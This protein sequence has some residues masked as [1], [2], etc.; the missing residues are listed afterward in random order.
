MASSF[1]QAA[2]E[3]DQ[4]QRHWNQ[5]WAAGPHK[6]KTTQRSKEQGRQAHNC[7]EETHALKI[8]GKWNKKRTYIHCRKDT[9]GRKIT[10]YTVICGVNIW[11]WPTL[12]IYQALLKVSFN[13]QS[14][15]YASRT[16]LI[17]TVK[18][19]IAS[20]KCRLTAKQTQGRSSHITRLFAQFYRLFAQFYLLCL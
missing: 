4:N 6:I 15:F 2:V 12:H 18:G 20:T 7:W 16:H 14:I 3:G 11:L 8:E 19:M 13:L 10:K 9:F 1:H 17:F 5:K